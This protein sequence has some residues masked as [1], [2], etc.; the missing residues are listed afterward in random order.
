D[1]KMPDDPYWNNTQRVSIDADCYVF[2]IPLLVRYDFKNTK[3]INYFAIGGLSSMLMKSEDYQ[4]AYYHIGNP[5]MYHADRTYTGNTH[6]FSNLQ[7]AVG[8]DKKIGSLFSIQAAPYLSL[9]LQ[10]VGE[11]QVN[12]F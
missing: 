4:Y 6:V 7:F 3:R 2:E 1:Y 11:G 8:I 10:G 9:P 5:Y 12:L